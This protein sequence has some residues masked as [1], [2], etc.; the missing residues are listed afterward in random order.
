MP[1][2]Y[3]DWRHHGACP[4]PCKDLIM[5]RRWHGNLLAAHR[6]ARRHAASCQ[7]VSISNSKVTAPLP[8]RD[9]NS[10]RY[11]FGVLGIWAVRWLCDGSG[12]LRLCGHCLPTVID[13]GREVPLLVLCIEVVICLAQNGC[14]LD[15]TDYFSWLLRISSTSLLLFSLNNIKSRR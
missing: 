14:L 6:C 15:R 1:H 12:W 4:V 7:H 11:Q 9:G 13:H 10:P 5:P 3:V 2:H 8:M